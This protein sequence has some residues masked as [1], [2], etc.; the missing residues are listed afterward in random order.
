VEAQEAAKQ[1]IN[2]AYVTWREAGGKW[3]N[4]RAS[5]HRLGWPSMPEMPATD[6]ASLSHGFETALRPP[7]PGGRRRTDEE[8]KAAGLPG[9]W[10]TRYEEACS[11]GGDR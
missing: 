6:S 1:A 2:A 7:W 9:E 10:P 5:R 4:V 8:I 3:S 11:V